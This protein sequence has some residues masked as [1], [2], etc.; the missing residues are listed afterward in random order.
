MDTITPEIAQPYYDLFHDD[1][2]NE[3]FDGFESDEDRFKKMYN[4]GGLFKY[5]KKGR[6][7]GSVLCERLQKKKINSKKVGM[8]VKTCD[9]PM[10][11]SGLA[12]PNR[13]CCR[14]IEHYMC[15]AQYFKEALITTFARS[16]NPY[17]KPYNVAF[18]SIER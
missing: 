15:P 17:L 3:Y 1:T 10:L 2:E 16:R 6:T 11:Y 9:K 12:Y 7:I 8:F 18:R 5:F 4:E 14:G 13:L